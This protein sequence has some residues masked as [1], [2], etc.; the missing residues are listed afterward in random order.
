MRWLPSCL[1]AVLL[2]LLLTAPAAARPA[3]RTLPAAAPPAAPTI[4]APAPPL[5]ENQTPRFCLAP[6]PVAGSLTYRARV[7]HNNRSALSYVHGEV[8]L[9]SGD[10][11]ETV[12]QSYILDWQQLPARMTPS[13]CALPSVWGV[14]GHS[15]QQLGAALPR[16][17][18]PLLR[19][20]ITGQLLAQPQS[21]VP[22]AQFLAGQLKIGT[23]QS[24][25]GG[26]EIVASFRG[27]PL[28]LVGHTA[29]QAGSAQPLLHDLAVLGPSSELYQYFFEDMAFAAQ[30]LATRPTLP[31]LDRA[32][33]VTFPAGGSQPVAIRPVKDWLVFQASLPNGRPLNLVFDSGAEQMVIDDMV[34]KLD[35]RLSPVG[36][37]AVGGALSDAPMQLY[38]GF[39]FD[40]GGVE[41]KNLSV[42]GTSLSQLGYGA[43]VRIHGVVGNEMLQLCK[44]DLDLENG[45]LTLLPPGSASPV[46]AQA[47]DIPLTFIRELP[48]I[49]AAVHNDKPALVLLDTGMRSPL[50][51]N[52]DFLEHYKLSDSLKMNGFLG[53]I[54]GGLLP[55][56][57]VE[58]LPVSVGGTTYTEKVADASAD[59]TYDYAGL[60]VIGSIGFPLLARHFGGITFD[61]ARKIV[62]LRDPAESRTFAG[63]PEAWK[64]LPQL[65][66]QMPEAPPAGAAGSQHRTSAQEMD[67]AATQMQLSRALP[68]GSRAQPPAAPLGLDPG[69]YGAYGSDMESAMALNPNTP[70]RAALLR[71]QAELRQT[72]R[73]DGAAL[74]QQLM[75]Y[76]EEL[77]ARLPAAVAQLLPVGPAPAAPGGNR[78]PAEPWSVPASTASPALPSDPRATAG[79]NQPTEH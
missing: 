42:A 64:Q 48:H 49:Q 17:D 29:P 54:T 33:Y 19:H 21:V 60:P 43:D 77:G 51:V 8:D 72:S 10:F 3:A 78:A 74:A 71:A 31:V 66:A 11:A 39:S 28:V 9:G 61:Y 63:R 47:Q 6:N 24:I 18:S 45:Q 62:T 57:I 13:R 35:S 44:L 4:T 41:F 75:A 50:A 12:D 67:A 70:A 69:G 38:E 1:G 79:R 2:G 37:M 65:T 46:T 30:P 27:A 40:V 15:A 23:V 52:L 34:L 53:D 22:N 58:N 59:S 26:Y 14:G 5:A 56:Y 55:R 25:P 36:D 73:R 7:I 32:S 76:S 68:P 20:F 16:F